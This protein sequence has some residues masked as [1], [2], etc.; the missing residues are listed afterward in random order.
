M[1]KDLTGQRFGKLVVIEETDPYYPSTY[2]T[3][4]RRYRRWLC[5]CDC[6]KETKVI[7]TSLLSGNTSSCGCG[8]AE[9]REKILIKPGSTRCKY[10]NEKR[11]KGI[12]VNMKCR[13][14][15]PKTKYYE[16]YGGRGIKVCD[17]WSKDGGSDAFCEWSLSHGYKDNLTIDRIDNDGDYSPDNCR[18]VDRA[19]QMSNTRRSVYFDYYGEMLT[20]PQI[21]RLR[22]CDSHILKW[23]LEN[24]WDLEKAINTPKKRYRKRSNEHE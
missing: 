24:G 9:N 1:K 17:E 8:C 20:A 19:E 12:L 2:K 5:K 23:R 7:Q 16:N 22:N 11:L 21:A 15:N 3:S 10:P 4:K 18:W 13:C 14:N 6:G